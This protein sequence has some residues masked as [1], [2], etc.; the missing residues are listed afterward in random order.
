M[1]WYDTFARVYDTSLEKHYAE[2][3]RLAVLALDLR[4]GSVVL[5]LPCGTGQSFDGLVDGVGASGRVVG[6]DLSAG[7]VREARR[8]IGRLKFTNVHVGEG[9]VHAL[10]PARIAA[11][12]G[13]PVVVDRLQVFL[14]MSVFPDHPRAFEQLWSLLAPGGRCVL[15]DVHA[16]RLTFQGRMVNWLAQAEIRRRFWEPLGRVAEGFE[17]RDLPSK[18]LHGGTVR[19]ATGTKPR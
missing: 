1:A 19:L 6:V 7:M 8:R 11:I 12:S 3:R 5:D 10:D 13:A 18:P 17:L 16:E 4:P 15:V 9:D 2:Q 14:G